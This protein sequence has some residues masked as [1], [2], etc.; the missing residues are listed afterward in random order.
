MSVH[1]NTICAVVA[2]TLHKL[3]RDVV[4]P[5]DVDSALIE[6]GI[7]TVGGRKAYTKGN[8][9]L[10][11]GGYLI[12][13]IGGWNL[14]PEAQTNVVIT[15]TVTPGM[16]A[17]RVFKQIAKATIQYKGIIELKMEA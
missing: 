11:G 3:G 16:A 9:F 14:T 10:T 8:G 12:R 15:A 2:N 7:D 5:A 6:A 4:S 17:G 13:C 1:T